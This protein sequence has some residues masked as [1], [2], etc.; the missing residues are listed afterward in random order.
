MRMRDCAGSR[1]GQLP[2]RHAETKIKHAETSWFHQQT[3]RSLFLVYI[4]HLSTLI[5]SGQTEFITAPIIRSILENRIV[6]VCLHG[7]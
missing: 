3:W 2:K 1:P 7:A 5:R 4:F 6:V